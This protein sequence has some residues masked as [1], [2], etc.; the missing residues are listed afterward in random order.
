MSE[1]LSIKKQNLGTK[2]NR[3]KETLLKRINS[4]VK[5]STEETLKA[6]L[7]QTKNTILEMKKDKLSLLRLKQLHSDLN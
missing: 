2:I 6:K 3:I 1:I 5:E 7:T 4:L